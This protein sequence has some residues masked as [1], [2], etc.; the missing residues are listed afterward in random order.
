MQGHVDGVGTILRRSPSE[1]WEVVE[2]GA[3]RRPWRRYVVDKGSITVDG[4]C[5]TVVEA[6]ADVVHGVP[7]PRDPRAHHPRDQQPGDLVNLEVDVIAKYVETAASTP[8]CR[9]APA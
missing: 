8:I 9:E 2:V 5:L 4:V 6:A 1:H 7:H 3:A